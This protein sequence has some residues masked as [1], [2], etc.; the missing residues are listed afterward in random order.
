MNNYRT[1]AQL[2]QDAKDTLRGKW[3]TGILLYLITM[4]YGWITGSIQSVLNFGNN[5]NPDNIN[6]MASTMR[7]T[8]LITIIVGLVITLIGNSADFQALDWIRNPELQFQP[9]QSNF[10]RFKN[11]D[12]YKLIGLNIV[13][14]VLVFLWSLLLVIPGIIK[15]MSYSQA[16]FIYKDLSDKDQANGYSLTD[17]ITR[18]R[19]LMDG[20]KA[21]YFVLQLSFIGWWLLAFITMGI[22]LIWLI[23]YYRLTMADFYRDLAE[24]NPK[25]V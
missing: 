23:P 19:Q 2:K 17:F 6:Q 14:G 16:Y 20:H 24:N 12:W 11:P 18:S 9:V 5:M 10:S 4:L 13:M 25:L 1:R 15:A 21:D 7:T 3:G 22:G 8:S